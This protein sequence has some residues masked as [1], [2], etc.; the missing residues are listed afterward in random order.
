M[1][2]VNYKIHNPEIVSIKELTGEK[3]SGASRR[4]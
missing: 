1:I 2:N 3:K 4:R